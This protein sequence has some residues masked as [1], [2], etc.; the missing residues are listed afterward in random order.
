MSKTKSI[1]VTILA[2]ILILVV[3]FFTFVSFPIPNSVKNYN[4]ILSTVGRGIDIS[5][6]YYVVLT[7][8]NTSTDKS[9]NVVEDAMNILRTRLDK[10]GYTEAVISVQD[11]NKI[12]VEIPQVD[13]ADSVLKV[14]GQTGELTFE[15]NSG[16]VWLTGEEHVKGAYVAQDT[17]NGGYLVVL[18]FTTKGQSKF[19]EATKAVLNS[20]DSTEDGKKLYIKLGGETISSPKVSEVINS[21]TAQITGYETYEDAQNIAAVIDSG[22]LPI[23]Y[24]VS[25]SRSISSKIGDDT[26]NKSAIA[27]AVGLGVILILLIIIYGGMGLAATFSLLV[28]V[29]LYVIFLAIIPGV[30]LTLPGIAGILLSIGMAVDANIVIFERVKE[31][32]RLG[33]TVRASISQGYKRAFIT[34]F[35]SNITTIFAALVLWLLCPGTIKGFAI[36]LLVGIVLSLFCGVLV[37]RWFIRVFSP[38]ASDERKFLKLKREGGSLND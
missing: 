35:D 12:R 22:R 31:E 30:Q 13:D 34:V 14:I 25:E 38:L 29:L 33:K 27:G 6:G 26:I 15:D 8:T 11:G 36:T 10:K 21:S 9:D 16:K 1:V 23:S 19:A 28:Y 37:T 4:S 2:S 17:Q 3:G 18:Q 7:P 20:S 24:E 32:Y 5:G